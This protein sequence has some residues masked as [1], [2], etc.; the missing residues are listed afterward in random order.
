MPG[1]NFLEGVAKDRAEGRRRTKLAGSLHVRAVYR[2][3][4][5]GICVLVSTEIKGEG[6]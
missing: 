6:P 2:N 4:R 1:I 5:F 3:E